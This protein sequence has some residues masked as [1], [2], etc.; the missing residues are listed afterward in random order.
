MMLAL[1]GSGSPSTDIPPMP[2]LY[3]S[4]RTNLISTLGERS[5]AI[6][7]LIETSGAICFEG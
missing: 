2:L 7:L 3:P 4:T 1:I 6:Y 5:S